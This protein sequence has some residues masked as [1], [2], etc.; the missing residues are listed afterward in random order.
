MVVLDA[1]VVLTFFPLYPFFLDL[2]S[3]RIAR[4]LAFF[5]PFDLPFLSRSVQDFS[6][7]L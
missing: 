7:L 6:S 2:F 4:T 1:F 5:S 3:A